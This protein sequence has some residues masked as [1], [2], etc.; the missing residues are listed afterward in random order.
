MSFLIVSGLSFGIT[1]GL[2]SIINILANS[3]GPG[4]VGIHG[5][6]PCYFITSAFLTM[7]LVFLHMF[8][9]TIFFNTC[10]KRHYWKLALAIVNPLVISGLVSGSGRRSGFPGF[11]LKCVFD[12][13][14]LRRQHWASTLSRLAV[15][16][17]RDPT[18]PFFLS[19]E[20]GRVNSPTCLK[21]SSK[22][23]FDL[24]SALC[25]QT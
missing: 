22:K 4:T 25:H 19:G 23:I 10:E 5:D 2:F 15:S 17:T 11:E 8:W 7:A 1:S 16:R 12:L 13:V 24:L 9:G 3:I 21:D 14:L 20:G 18:H 6:S